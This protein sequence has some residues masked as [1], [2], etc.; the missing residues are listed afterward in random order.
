MS[1]DKKLKRLLH[2]PIDKPFDIKTHEQR[3]KEYAEIMGVT[4]LEEAKGSDWIAS[5]MERSLLPPN[6]RQ[7]FNQIRHPLSEEKI[8]VEIRK[9]EV[10][11]KIKKV[12]E[13]LGKEVRDLDG[14]TKF[15]Y[16][17]RNL[18][19]SVKD[20]LKEENW[21]RYV[22]L[23]PGDTRIPDH[24]IW[25][26]LKVTSAVNAF[27]NFQNNSLFLFTLG[28][29]QFFISQ[30]R[31]TQDLFMGSFLLSY[32]T[33]IAMREVIDD[34]GPTSIIYPDLFSQPLMDNYLEN[35]KV[36][37]INS[38]SSYVNYPTIPNRFVA[39]IPQSEKE[40]ISELAQKM[41]ERVKKEWR[42]I[43]KN[44]LENFKITL[45]DDLIKKQTSD[46]PAIYWVAIPW[47][48]GEHDV[49]VEDFKD[50]IEENEIKRLEEIWNF[51][52]KE[53]EFKPNIGL[54]YQVLYASLE[55]SIGARKNQRKF[56]KTE[57]KGKK[58]SICGEKEA[59]IGAD[60]IKIGKSISEKEKL[61]IPCFVK[62]GLEKYLETKFGDTF[63]DFTFP[64]TAEVSSSDFKERVIK[65]ANHEFKEY[66]TT[67]KD[68]AK[69]KFQKVD[70]LPK[71]KDL[72]GPLENL[73]GE[74]FFEE[75]LTTKAFK[76]FLGGDVE[77]EELEKMKKKLIKITNKIGKP[78]PYFAVL[79]L[80]GDNMGKWLSGKLLPQIEYAY[81]SNVWDNLSEDFKN[82]LKNLVSKKFLTPAIHSAI[83][84]ALRNYSLVFTK[85]IVEEEHLGKLVYAGGDD[86][87][88]FVN[89]KDLFEI[90]RKLRAAFSGHIVFK[91]EEIKVNWKNK[92]GFVEKSG[93]YL[94]T[95]GENASLSA[96]IVI[97]HYK[98][99]LKI[100]LDKVR[101]MKKEAKSFENKDAF[102]I[103]LLKHSGE[104]RIGKSKWR[105]GELDVIGSLKNLSNYMVKG[106]AQSYFSDKFI[107]N[108]RSEF[109][110]LKDSSGNFICSGEILNIELK[111]LFSRAYNGPKKTKEEI[112]Q[113]I[114]EPLK[115]IFWKTG[116]N[117]D[118]FLH[119][120]EISSFINKGE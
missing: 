115:E 9:E 4:N 14:K 28:P 59:L 114:F 55:K 6:I 102:A 12:Y 34:Y 29:V 38:Y 82:E 75:N 2:D 65:E 112:V 17:W 100:V 20:E 21:S 109:S 46:F 81:N 84:T 56:T 116:S 83:S 32:L 76:N 92:S 36:E 60:K 23:I 37:V 48:K 8:Q 97:A 26:H 39:I 106:K 16:L 95:M 10:L 86:V 49:K 19:E 67:F 58:C 110:R 85:K 54:L 30:A 52:A 22:P 117:I 91:D 89:L 62:R 27:E 7:E 24:S 40:K 33:F 78:N 45:S 99:P 119:L 71:L 72:F 41:T 3:A 105:Y 61:C 108:T 43:V 74:W 104:E 13:N 96:G 70:P 98:T 11:N 31:K 25:E 79:M 51:A 15:L 103:A 118:N 68:L 63:K 87:L 47:R 93:N 57:E 77:K 94:L 113:N 73:E 44:V 50:F 42:E 120:L 69:D 101:I 80:D 111:R 107:Y 35:M 18:Q 88:A 1:F 90:L 66:L 53:G 64:S 5:C